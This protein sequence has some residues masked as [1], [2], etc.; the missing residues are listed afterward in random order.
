MEPLSGLDAAF[1]AMETPTSRLHVAAVLVLDPPDRERTAPGTLDGAIQRFEAIKTVV[2][3]RVPRVPRLLRRVVRAPLDVQRPV[4][5]EVAEID[6]DAHVRRARVAAPGSQ[7]EL[8][9]LVG[10]VLSRPLPVDR[11]PW[12]MVVA[13]GLSGGRLA[14]IARL[15]HAIVDG[16]SGATALA[17]FLDLAPEGCDVDAPGGLSDGSPPQ[18]LSGGFDVPRSVNG[19]G[20]PSELGMWEHA[21]ATLASRWDTAVALLER[22]ADVLVALNRQNRVLEANGLSPPPAPFSAPR[23]SLNGAV[24]GERRIAT[25]P[26][27]VADLELVRRVLGTG[28]GVPRRSRRA[29]VNDVILSAVGGALRRYLEARDEWPARPL[30]ALVPISTRGPASV[31]ASRLAHVGNH[32]SGMLVPLATT[33]GDPIER[34]QAVATATEVAKTQEELAGGE[35]LE[36]LLRAVPPFLV[37]GIMRTV[38]RVSLFDHVAP[39]VNM[40][41]S[42][43]VVP[44]VQLWWAGCPVSAIYPAAPVAD[45]IGLNITS[46]TYRG[47]VHFGIV[48]CPRLVPDVDEVAVLLDDAI[49]ELVAAALDATG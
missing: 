30:V 17:A 23:T 42:S 45:G 36:T 12:E 49:A 20:R 40:V 27:P 8:D 9:A 35:F 21:A 25:L 5:G 33:M 48:G 28:A 38:G 15:H 47:T 6:L 44:D 29:T 32:V 43:I 22:S 1:L 24:T 26:V 46:M 2:G 13:E 16:V 41:V 39:P 14:V 34:L 31:P 18:G 7:R 3:E 19:K 37:S 11:P 10:E 4:W